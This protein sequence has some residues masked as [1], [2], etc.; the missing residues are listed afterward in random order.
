MKGQICERSTNVGADLPLWPTNIGTNKGNLGNHR[1]TTSLRSDRQFS[2]TESRFPS[3]QKNKMTVCVQCTYQAG[4]LITPVT[5]F[6]T[7]HQSYPSTSPSSSHVSHLHRRQKL[8]RRFLL[9]ISPVNRNP[10]SF[11][12]LAISR[13]RWR[14]MRRSSRRDRRRT[15]D[16]HRRRQ[17]DESR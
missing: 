7:L 9:Y 15:P 5:G 11:P 17:T 14:T 6:P 2:L 3:I 8:H 1:K 10:R 4:N 16:R 12:F 13:S